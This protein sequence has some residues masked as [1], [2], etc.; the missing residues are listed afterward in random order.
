MRILSFPLRCI[1]QVL[2]SPPEMHSRGKHLMLRVRKAHLVI[3]RRRHTCTEHYL[4]LKLSRWEFN[5]RAC[6]ILNPCSTHD[7]RHTELQGAYAQPVT[8]QRTYLKHEL[9]TP[10]V[11][12]PVHFSI[13]PLFGYSLWGRQF[14]APCSLLPAS[15]ADLENGHT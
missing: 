2:F 1:V 9:V 14:P 6:T 12:R 7:S 13:S 8:L 3:F 5:C 10:A 4:L 11:D 15:P